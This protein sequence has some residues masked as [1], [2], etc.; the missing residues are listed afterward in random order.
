MKPEWD[1]AL[2]AYDE[3][4]DVLEGLRNDYVAFLRASFETFG[5]RLVEA[6]GKPWMG[7]FY[8]KAETATPKVS[9]V[10]RPREGSPVSVWLWAAAPNG[11]PKGMLRI[12]LALDSEPG[13]AKTEADEQAKRWR[14]LAALART[15]VSDLPGEARSA[16]QHPDTADNSLWIH[17]IPL[18]GAKSDDT[19]RA[20]MRFSDAASAVDEIV[21]LCAW[22][23]E[24]LVP[25]TSKKVPSNAWS[26]ARWEAQKL[27]PWE[28]GW[29]VQ[30]ER[31]D[32]DDDCAWVAVRP[33]GELVFGHARTAVHAA[34]C[35]ALDARNLDLE[36]PRE[37]QHQRHAVI[38]EEA[39]VR[40]LRRA[41]KAEA[42]RTRALEAFKAYFDLDRAGGQRR[43]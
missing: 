22:L 3:K 23:G 38:L 26:G 41:D 16:T 40:A 32:G 37:Y 29:Y 31:P 10:A 4:I 36:V 9:W 5:G 34:L 25:L 28:G 35:K 27:K 2:A 33:P 15:A 43:A 8:P 30:V 13:Y 39:R 14:L 6:R 19:F 42:I 7:S 11:G 18:L 21:Q 12:A 20:L 24:A 1:E 17:T